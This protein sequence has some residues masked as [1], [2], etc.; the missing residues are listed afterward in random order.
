MNVIDWIR[1]SSHYMTKVRPDLYTP[2]VASAHLVNAME[3]LRGNYG[4]KEM[5]ILISGGFALVRIIESP[6]MEEFY[7]TKSISS[8]T[9]F[10]QENTCVVLGFVDDINLPSV[11]EAFEEEVDNDED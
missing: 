9:T 8:V 2:E 5:S 7:L 3:F 10:E 11:D 4:P 6:G 1:E